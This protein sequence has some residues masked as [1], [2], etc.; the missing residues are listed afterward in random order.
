M[1]LFYFTVYDLATCQTGAKTHIEK[2]IEGL[3]RLGW[4]I[5]LF[6]CTESLS[7]IKPR[8]DFKHICI[9]RRDISLVQHIRTQM[10]ITRSLIWG[11]H[12]RPEAVYIRASFANLVPVLW[13]VWHR[14]PFFYEINGAAEFSTSHR[15]LLPVV[16]SWENWVL[17]RA[18]GVITTTQEMADHFRARA[19]LS[20]EKF[21]VIPMASG[22]PDLAGPGGAGE[23]REGKRGRIGYVGSLSE[24]CGAETLL[25][26]MATVGA[27]YPDV[28]L[29]IVG[30]G[31]EKQE[32]ISL[33]AE[34]GIFDKVQFFESLW[35]DD[36][37]RFYN[38]CEIL[39]APYY[40][41]FRYQRPMGSPTKIFEYLACGRMVVTSDLP[42]LKTFRGCPGIWFCRPDDPEDLGRVIVEI[43]SLPVK[44]RKELGRRAQEYIKANHTWRHRID[45]TSNFILQRCKGKVL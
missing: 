4:E 13:A 42:A 43:L 21:E 11:R 38:D 35:G 16:L 15:H 1:K 40:G 5:T 33:A 25:R 36:V 8:F 32:Y 44:R 37:L 19:G 9:H 2:I 29:R 34:L 41:G 28:T 24:H 22:C 12:E 6:S 18:A 3:D 14:I 7:N 39:A 17:R 45:Q 23:I 20:D 31:P 10:R 26:S 30:S 27:A